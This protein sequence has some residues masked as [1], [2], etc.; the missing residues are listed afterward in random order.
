MMGYEKLIESPLGALTL[1]SDGTSLNA[2]RFGDCR[3]DG[4]S[5]VVLERAA[6]ELAEYFSGARRGFSV[7]INGGGTPFQ[8][9]VWQALCA[10]PYGE[11]ASYGEIAQRIGKGKA[12]RAVGSACNRNPLAIIVPCHR[13]VGKNGVLTGYAGGTERKDFLL[14]L[15]REY[16]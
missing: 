16:R 7:P 3:R 1:C 10:I 14:K 4:S 2:V 13:V 9:A 12:V 5:C 6:E 15:E 8:Q 11:T